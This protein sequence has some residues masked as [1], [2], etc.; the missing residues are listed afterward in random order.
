MIALLLIL[1]VS[2][3]FTQILSIPSIVCMQYWMAGACGGNK[4][5]ALWPVILWV[6]YHISIP[7]T[8]YADRVI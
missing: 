6:E 8:C 1:I 5:L 4:G 7:G 3:S 2:V